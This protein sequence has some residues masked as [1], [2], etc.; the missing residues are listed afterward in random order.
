NTEDGRGARDRPV[1][2]TY[3]AGSVMKVFSVATALEDGVVTPE[4]VRVPAPA[5]AAWLEL[6]HAPAY[7]AA[8]MNQTLPAA[9]VRRIGLPVTPEVALR[10]R[11]ANGGTLLAARLALE[12]GLACNT[13]GGS[14]HA[15]ADH[16]SGFCVFNDVAVAIRV[17]LA[18]ARIKRA[19]V[20]D[21]DV[22][23]GDGTA[24]IFRGEPCVFTFSMHCRT[25]FPLHKQASDL[26]LALDAGLEDEAYLA[27]LAAHLPGLLEEVRP[28]VVFFDAGV[29]PHVDDRLGRL[30]LSAAGI[31][32]RERLVLETCLKAGVPVVGV[33]GGGYAPDLEQLVRLH[34]ILPRVASEL[35]R[36]L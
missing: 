21:L 8:V 14:H 30:A 24:A 1:T 19:L 13:A 4:Q 20:V 31:E 6:A 12:H 36:K 26:D 3:E 16:G 17:L 27:L 34:A 23:Q 7:V 22:H 5:P 28:D 18:E 29:D 35:F 9:A 25:N 11:A 32:R 10:A 33:V 15:F 2:D